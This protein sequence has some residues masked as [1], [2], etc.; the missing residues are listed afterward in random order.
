MARHPRWTRRFLRDEDFDA[1][2]EAIR[3]AEARTSGEIRVHLERRV[4]R[5]RGA[6]PG[7]ALARARHV[8]A[9][10]GMH[11]TKERHGVLIY[12]AVEHRKLAVVGDQGIHDCVGEQHWARVRDLMVE[13]L[14]AGAPRD[15]LLSAI[16]AVGAELTRHFPRR[17][18][19]ADELSN[20]VSVD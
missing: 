13:K 20:Q 8:F 1:V 16:A 19:D 2:T 12:L 14:R 11:R 5:V 15:A 6:P 18:G 7:D 17:P 3:R 9:R 4:H 10:L